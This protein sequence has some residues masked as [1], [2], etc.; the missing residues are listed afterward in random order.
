MSIS[1]SGILCFHFRIRIPDSQRIQLLRF[2]EERSGS[3]QPDIRILIDQDSPVF[4]HRH[5]FIR[6]FQN[7]QPNRTSL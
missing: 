1:L 4:L 3:D 7:S 6:N 2:I 5:F